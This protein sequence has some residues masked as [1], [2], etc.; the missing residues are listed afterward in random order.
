MPSLD[1]LLQ[2]LFSIFMSNKLGSVKVASESDLCF[3]E[4]CIGFS[5]GDTCTPFVVS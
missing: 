2:I 4:L 1:A 5:S 3:L